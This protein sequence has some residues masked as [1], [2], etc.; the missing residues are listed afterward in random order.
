MGKHA[1]YYKVIEPCGK[2][3]EIQ[4]T[5]KDLVESGYPGCKVLLMRYFLFNCLG[6][7]VGNAKG[8]TT[9]KGAQMAFN[10]HKMQVYLLDLAHCSDLP[11]NSSGTVTIGKI[12][13]L[14]VESVE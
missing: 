3:F 8:Y 1:E 7:V 6:Q 4:S 9:L 11:V 10:R 13:H 5:C 12:K 2:T 14:T